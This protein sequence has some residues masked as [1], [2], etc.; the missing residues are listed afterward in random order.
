[1]Q[2]RHSD[3]ERYFNELAE[4]S[5]SYYLDYIKEHKAIG[6]G[7]RVLEI[8]C[9]EGGNLLPFAQSGCSVTG[10]DL[11]SQKIEEGKKLFEKYGEEASLFQADFFNFQGRERELFDLLIV[12]DVIEHIESGMKMDFLKKAGEMLKPGGI[13]FFAFPAWQMPFGGHQQ[14]CASG[15][16]SRFPFLHLLPFGL[17]KACL[18]LFGEKEA[19]IEELMSIKRSKMTIEGF[20]ALCEKAG[21]LIADRRLWFIN[22]HYKVKFKLSPKKLWSLLGRIPYIRNFFST[23]CFYIIS[24][25]KKSN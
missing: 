2:K 1:M 18:K 24:P 11:S 14:I 8:G 20:E 6:E 21:F 12:H 25:V 23:S 9:G 19:C 17:Y 22:P 13:A 16:L 5:R 7:F 3:R 10:M 15:L 4:T